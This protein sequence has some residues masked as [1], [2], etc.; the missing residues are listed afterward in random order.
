MP[1]YTAGKPENKT[2]IVPPGDYKLKV[3]AA[4]DDTSKTGNDMIELQLRII[5][6]DGS[7]GPSLF[8]YLVFTQSSFWK[9]DAFLKSADKHPGEGQSVN[10]NADDLIGYEVRATLKVEKYDGKESN[11]V[12]AYLFE[13][14]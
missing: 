6:D 7:N 9:V 11:K 4:K 5:H 2:F 10:V 1:K 14:F 8:D 13:D 3:I 12:A